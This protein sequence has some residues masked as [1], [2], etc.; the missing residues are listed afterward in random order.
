M[1]LYVTD[2]LVPNLSG[3]KLTPAQLAYNVSHLMIASRTW[4][5]IFLDLTDD[6]PDGSLVYLRGKCKDLAVACPSHPSLHILHLLVD[7]YPEN[8][9][10]LRKAYLKGVSV[11]GL[12]PEVWEHGDNHRG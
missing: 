4:D 6:I 11:H 12:L 7:L 5:K 1:T 8:S 2:R 9:G 10:K 3:C